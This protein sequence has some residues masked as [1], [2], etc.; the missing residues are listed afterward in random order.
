[1]AKSVGKVFKETP[2]IA[3][4]L[5]FTFLPMPDNMDE[6]TNSTNAQVGV[7]CATADKADACTLYATD[8]VVRTPGP[9]PLHCPPQPLCPIF[10]V[11]H[12]GRPY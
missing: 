10:Y 4:S 8:C 1:M 11:V 3:A 12:T 2:D 6:G 5:N 7:G 9:M